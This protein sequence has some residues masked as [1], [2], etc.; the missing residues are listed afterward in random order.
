MRIIDMF[1][2]KLMIN[3]ADASSSMWKEHANLC[4]Q[5]H[6]GQMF[7]HVSQE[8]KAHISVANEAANTYGVDPDHHLELQAGQWET[9]WHRTIDKI[10]KAIYHVLGKLVQMAKEDVDID[11]TLDVENMMTLLK[12]I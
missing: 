10:S 8:D 1:D 11:N 5:K 9:N 7:R 3:A 12:D 2:K 6:G 4:F